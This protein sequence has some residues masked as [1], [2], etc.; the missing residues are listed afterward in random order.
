MHRTDTEWEDALMFKTFGFQFINSYGPAFYIAFVQSA[1]WTIPFLSLGTDDEGN[2]IPLRDHCLEDK[3]YKAIYLQ[4][5]IIILTKQVLRNFLAIVPPI[6]NYAV[7]GYVAIFAVAFPIGTIVCW[8]NNRADAFKINNLMQRPR[9]MGAQD[10]GSMQTILEAVAVISVFT[11]CGILYLS[12]EAYYSYFPVSWGERPNFKVFVFTIVV[13]HLV[14]LMKQV[15]AQLIPDTPSWVEMGPTVSRPHGSGVL[16][17][18]CHGGARSSSRTETTTIQAGSRDWPRHCA[19]PAREGIVPGSH[20]DGPASRAAPARP[21][22]VH[23]AHL[24]GRRQANSASW[25]GQARCSGGEGG[26]RGTA[27]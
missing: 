19:G 27:D 10:I 6:I 24:C 8:L 5:L 2:D 20:P 18:D 15:V 25:A 12:S 7:F 26:W 22:A 21:P 13:E 11:N 17:C 3:C 14:L 1:H 16:G 4:M 23:A 9:Y